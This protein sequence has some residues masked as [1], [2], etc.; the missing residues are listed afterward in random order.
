MSWALV[1]MMGGAVRK[2]PSSF[3]YSLALSFGVLHFQFQIS[4]MSWPYLSMYCLC[5]ISLSCI[6]RFR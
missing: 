3:W 2:P 5:S 1:S 6:I 4:G